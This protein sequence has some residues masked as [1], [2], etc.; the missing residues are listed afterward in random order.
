[1]EKDKLKYNTIGQYIN[2]FLQ[3][4]REKFKITYSVRF[5]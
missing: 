2:C 1:M 3:N 4:I 5:D